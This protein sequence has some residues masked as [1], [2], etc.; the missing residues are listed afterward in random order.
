MTKVILRQ[1][2]LATS[3]LAAPGWAMA[4]TAVA[5]SAGAASPPAAASATP[6]T[7]AEIVVTAQ[8]RTE[9]L[10]DVPLS[11]T[12]ASGAQLAKQGITDPSQLEKVVPGFTYQESTFGNP[13]FTIRGVGLY[14]TSIGASPT[15]T[16]YVDQ[17]PLPYLAMTPGAGLDLERL[18]ALKGP[19]GI[20]FGENST[21]GAINY[22]AAKPTDS[23]HAGGDVTYGR[24]NQVDLNGYVSGP[25]ADTLTGRLAVRR[26]TQDGWQT[27][28]SRPGDT[29]G[30]RDFTAAR[31]LLDWK[32]TDRLK[33][34]FNANAWWD[35]SDTQAAQ[36]EGFAAAR[37]PAEGGYTEAATAL[38]GL[39]PAPHDARAADWDA[40]ASLRRNDRFQQASIHADLDLGG[41]ATLT[42][43]T[44]YSHLDSYIPTDDDGT[45]FNDFSELITGRI[46]SVFQE[47][48][49]AG[50]LGNRI[51]YTV[52][53]NY[54]H[55]LVDE[56]DLGSFDASNSG[57]GPFRY[58]DF[59]NISDQKVSTEGV[60]GSA[61]FKL[62]DTLTLQGGL[63]YTNQD[64][65]FLGCLADAGDGAL[66]AGIAAL[67]AS[68]GLGYHPASPGACVTLNDATLATLPVVKNKLD[69]D[70]LSW[71]AG[72]NWKPQRNTLIYANITKGYKSGAFT[73]LP[74]VFASEL[75]PVTQES[76]LAYEIGFKT[77][78]LDRILQVSGAG[79][80]YD[81]KNKQ[82]LGYKSFP[83]LGLNLPALQNIPTSSVTGGELEATLRPIRGLK[84]TA[85]ATYVASSVDGHLITPDPFS[86]P[87]DIKG[88]SFPNTPKWQIVSDTE[89]D[90]PVTD[91]L[92]GFVGG[93][94]TYKSTSNAAFGGAPQFEIKDYALLDLRAGVEAP[95]GRW[96]V[97]VWGRNVTNQ[98]YLVNV[99]HVTDTIAALTGRPS[100][101]GV[102]LSAQY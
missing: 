99:A 68:A 55:D 12:A 98:Y 96:R 2:L 69:Q 34:E 81:Y 54:Q 19:Q 26:D 40:G 41:G 85:G 83:A 48:R 17:V 5:A 31:L 102:T 88:E 62:T 39:Q 51:R 42:S 4:Q 87:I 72:L 67:P 49:L 28:A 37:P 84:I 63:R 33:V 11:I 74:A 66:A 77:E 27:S 59:T 25:I 75:A 16:V 36:Y 82:I 73:P 94:L 70:N 86:N 90:F 91:T 93:S 44:A 13:V 15:V 18:E 78:L 9:R 80:Y 6:D 92:S 46:E 79:F 20:L 71:R 22:I 21:G 1:L 95:G 61:D 47:L 58:H 53:A 29:L 10:S 32:P 50:P 3:I 60:F 43:I 23:P 101:Y 97:Q 56:H 100:S 8:K 38:A 57:I 14:D 89:Y 52:G 65:A 7:T 76:V 24:F 35:R 30:R 45:A 64:R